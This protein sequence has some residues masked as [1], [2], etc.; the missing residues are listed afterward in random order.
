[1]SWC[2]LSSRCGFIFERYY[3]SNNNFPNFVHTINWTISCW[4]THVDFCFVFSINVPKYWQKKNFICISDHEFRISQ[5]SA[6]NILVPMKL[7]KTIEKCKEQ[8]FL[9]VWAL[10]NLNDRIT[11]TVGGKLGRYYSIVLK[12]TA[13]FS[14]EIRSYIMLLTK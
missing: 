13:K 3:I 9:S 5:A 12:P 4:W 7:K 11:I 2:V 10:L 14:L 1:M 8:D 6:Y